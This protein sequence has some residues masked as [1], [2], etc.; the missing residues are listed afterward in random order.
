MPLLIRTWNVFHGRT[1]P[2]GWRG[3]LKRMV[4]LATSDEP[5]VLALQEVPIWALA[6][7]DGW[8]GMHS[9]GT[10][11][12]PALLG[13]LARWLQPVAPKIV[14]SPWTGQANALLLGPRVRPKGDVRVLELNPGGPQERRVAQIVPVEHEGRRL[15]LVNLHA[16]KRSEAARAELARLAAALADGSPAIVCGDLNVRATGL[17]GFSAPLPGIDQVLA[18]GLVVERGAKRWQD[19]CRRHGARLLSDH[20][21]TDAV[22]TSP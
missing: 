16:S 21:P 11:T 8:S 3:H 2:E 1:S 19:E 6:E 18:R 13:P 17:P 7:L 4:R 10:V 22:I 9:I 20:A 5:G 12:K 15:L 14:R